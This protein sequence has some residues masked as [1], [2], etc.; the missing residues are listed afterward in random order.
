MAQL[1]RPPL[2]CVFLQKSLSV[3]APAGLEWERRVQEYEEQDDGEEPGLWTRFR[4]LLLSLSLQLYHR[5]L[6]QRDALQR[7][8][9]SLE[10]GANRVR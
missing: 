8:L 6:K 4:G 9:R 5:M 7:L 10:E 1:W 3:P 2:S